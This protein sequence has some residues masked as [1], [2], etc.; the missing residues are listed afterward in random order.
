M[1]KEEERRTA[2]GIKNRK[3]GVKAGFEVRTDLA[4]EEKESFKGDDGGLS[5]S[6]E[7]PSPK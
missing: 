7:S 1:K 2:M 4:L 3:E 5:L 6:L